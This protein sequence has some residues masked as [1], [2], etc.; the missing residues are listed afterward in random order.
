V[1]EDPFLGANGAWDKILGIVGDQGNKF[2]FNGVAP[3]QIAEGSAD[4]GRH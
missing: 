1:L 2:F 3:V 4:E